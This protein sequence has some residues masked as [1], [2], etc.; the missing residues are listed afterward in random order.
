M[1][2][3]GVAVALAAAGGTLVL[4]LASCAGKSSKAGENGGTEAAILG[5]RDVATVGRADLESGVPIS[6]NLKPLVDVQINSPFPELIDQVLVREGEA[7]RR[8]QVLARFHASALAPAAA[9]AEAQLKMAR[10]DHERMRNLLKEGAVSERDLEGAEAAHRAAESAAAAARKSLDEA[11]VRSPV[12]GV[13]AARFVQSGDRV[14]DGVP[15]FQ[16]VNTARL[17]F[18]AT[19]PSEHISRVHVGAPVGLNVSGYPE[20]EVSG[21]VARVNASA[22]PATRQ[23]RVYVEVANP[24]GKLVG[25]LFASGRIVTA[26]AGAVLCVPRAGLRRDPAGKSYV[27]VVEGG[28]IARRDVEPGLADESRD[29]VEIRSG[30]RGGEAAVV[31]PVEGLIPGQAVQVSGKGA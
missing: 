3:A 26:S 23:V 10:A 17:E 19:V 7:V 18:E 30:L 31:G 6:G 25:G 21:R 4:L 24:G 1:R 11:T 27:W 15:M 8:G 9:S 16:V 5:E 20:G 29:L 2:R 12:D 28:R 14:K 22:D 13:V